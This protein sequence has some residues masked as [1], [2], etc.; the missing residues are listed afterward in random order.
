MS[1]REKYLGKILETKNYGSYEVID[2]VNW[3]NITVR[4]IQTG[5]VTKTRLEHLKDGVIKDYLYPSIYGIGCYGSPDTHCK[6]PA[7][8][9]WLGILRRCYDEDRVE[10]AYYDVNVCTQWHNF[11]NFETW[12]TKQPNF[13]TKGWELDKDLLIKGNKLY[14]PETCVYIPKAVNAALTKRENCRGE[15]PIGVRFSKSGK[16]FEAWCGDGER[17]RYLGVFRT[18]TE[19]FLCYKAK[20]EEMLRSLAEKYKDELDPRAYQALYNYQVEITD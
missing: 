14:S 15:L 4:F 11:L 12:V 1:H 19:A 17:S 20:K 10:A 6:S 2:Y 16:R 3:E 13:D 5:Y 7:A 9:V 8:V 18:V